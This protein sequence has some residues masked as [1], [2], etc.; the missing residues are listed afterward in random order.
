MSGTRIT[1]LAAGTP[2]GTDLSCAV[3]TTDTSMAPTGTDKKYLLSD[4]KTFIAPSFSMASGEILYSTG[5]NSV[6][7]A[8]NLLW[9]NGTTKLTLNGT[10]VIS[11]FT[12]DGVLHNDDTGNILSSLIVDA[13]ITN[14]TITNSK[15]ADMVAHTIK[16]NNTG[17]TSEIGRAHV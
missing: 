16:G 17:S 9:N 3:D 6:A 13:D 1:G 11:P 12:N 10:M 7:G 2:K 14:S 15:L 5:A 4:L 8:P